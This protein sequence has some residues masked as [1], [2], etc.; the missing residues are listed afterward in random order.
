MSSIRTADQ[1]SSEIDQEE[2]LMYI[3]QKNGNY[4][5]A[6][7]SRLKLEQFKKDL[8]AR[9]VYEMEMRHKR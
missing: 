5:D 8:E 7:K 9:T 3:H 1:I 6:E 4:A 2:K